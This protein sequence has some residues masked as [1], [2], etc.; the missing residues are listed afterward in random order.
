MSELLS[1]E[2]TLNDAG[3][4]YHLNIGNEDIANT[5]ILVGD[6]T[7]VKLVASFFDAITFE[8]QHREFA[9]ITGVYQ[10]K[11]ISVISHGIGCDNMD[12]VL[13]EIDAAV[14][15]DLATRKVKS[16]LTQLNLIRIG[17]CGALQAEIEVGSAIISKYAIGMDGV[18]NFYDIPFGDKIQDGLKAFNAHMAWEKPS[19]I[20]YMAMADQGLVNLLSDLGKEGITI[21]A[22]GFYGPQ[23]RSIRIPLKDENFKTKIRTFEWDGEQVLNLEMETS[24]L[25]SLA[26]ALGHQAVTICLAIANRYN[27]SFVS[28]FEATMCQ[29]IKNVL[30]KTLKL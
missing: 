18:A 6:Q 12:I 3:K 2:L 28:D 23:G 8:T 16:G 17:T 7:R 1:S 24:G 4:L 10:G 19:V 22:N 15:I 20:P 27:H 26:E 21:T 25:L 5:I 29:L 30:D 11:S 13:T 14:N 9:T